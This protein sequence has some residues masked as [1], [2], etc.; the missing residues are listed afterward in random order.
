MVSP[1]KDRSAIGIEAHGLIG[2]MR[3]TALVSTEGVIDFMCFPRIDSPTVFGSLLHP[4]RGGAFSITPAFEVSRTKQMYLPETNVLLTR[5][6]SARAV[7]EI[8]DF[9]PVADVEDDAKA[10]SNCVV[11]I[12]RAISGDMSAQMRCAP[13]FDYA[14]S[15]HET[16]QV[17]ANTL[18]FTPASQA[19][20][21]QTEALTLDA[22]V[23]LSIDHDDAV[24]SF[25]LKQ[26]EI[27]CFIFGAQSE[28]MRKTLPCKRALS[29]TIDFWREWSGQSTYHGR[30]REVV[31]RSALL[32]KLLSSRA[33]G[34]IVAAPTFGLPE[35]SDGGRRWDYR[36]TW[37]RDA[38]FSVYAL[39]RLGY[40]GEA[41]NFKDWIAERNKQCGS[42]GSFSV[43]YAVDGEE[44][45]EEEIVPELYGSGAAPPL[46][47]NAARDQTQ[48]DVYGA[49]LD[50]IY[51]YNKY[52]E[53][54]SYDGW[55]HVTRTVN[56]VAKNWE[57]AD[58]GIWEFRNGGRPLLHSRLMCWVAMDR[59]IRLAQ[60]RSLPAPFAEWNEVRDAI[61]EDIYTHFWNDEIQSFVQTPDSK[62]LDASTLMMPLVRFIGPKDPRWLSTLDAIGSG[63]GVDP[64]IFRYTRGDTL[65]G[66]PGE[67]GGFSAC[68]F[69]YAEALVRAG[70]VDEGRLIFEKMLAYA[71]HVG[72]YS[73]EV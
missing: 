27:A 17:D 71:N 5:F 68:S 35:T 63:L 51:L 11:R 12:V 20:D 22:T 34:A 2:N 9:M 31:M 48:L 64:L 49:L 47:G 44:S 66:L 10:T 28:V 19:A 43:M 38:A 25:D 32:L 23:S 36:Y 29:D 1:R 67:E 18:R 6:M 61:H 4:E 24:A 50:A 16:A 13:R 73:E 53:A 46:I 54:I 26:D 21:A 30:Y 72:L 41:R 3:T 39:L 52:G 59:A 60:K 69:W 57:Q 56:F 55:R 14:R 7:C 65:D 33:T 40:T 62:T 37:I 58:Q 42:D 70:R 45:P 8:V 15:S